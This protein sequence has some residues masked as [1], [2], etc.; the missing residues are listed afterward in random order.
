[1]RFNQLIESG[2]RNSE[3]VVAMGMFRDLRRAWRERRNEILRLQAVASDRAGIIAAA[4]KGLRLLLQTGLLAAG[5]YL[6]INDQ[7]SAGVIIAS[8]ILV[9]RALAPVESAIVR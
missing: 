3:V 7:I 8:S 1:M 4:S 9:G 2:L 5:A 6:A